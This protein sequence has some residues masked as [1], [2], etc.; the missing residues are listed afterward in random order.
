M[1]SFQSVEGGCPPTW[2][3]EEYT[4]LGI[5]SLFMLMDDGNAKV[6]RNDLIL[7][8]QWILAPSSKESDAPPK[9]YNQELTQ[10]Q[11]DEER[12]RF[13]Q[14]CQST[15]VAAEQFL[16]ACHTPSHLPSHPRGHAQMY[17]SRH[18]SEDFLP[19]IKVSN[20]S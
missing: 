7:Q 17:L 14:A 6:N 3:L 19:L 15:M 2:G 20:L 16:K 10:A 4:K 18:V 8:M 1:W 5:L 11:V 13:Y 9:D 12:E